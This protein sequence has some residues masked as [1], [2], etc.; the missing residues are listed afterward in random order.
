M[1]LKF[2]A[3]AALSAL[4][5]SSAWAA[6]QRPPAD[7]KPLSAIAK[8]LE[9]GGFTVVEANFDDGR[10]KIEAFRNTE[11]RELRVHPV[12]GAIIS[13]RLDDDHRSQ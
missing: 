13:N 10:W 9:D 12:T 6:D 2:F 7:A 5:L 11:K 4:A 8:S 3:T 1:Y